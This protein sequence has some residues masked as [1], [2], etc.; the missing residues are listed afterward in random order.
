MSTKKAARVLGVPVQLKLKITVKF[1]F[2]IF[3]VLRN[4]R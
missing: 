2:S 1:S 3:I 4:S